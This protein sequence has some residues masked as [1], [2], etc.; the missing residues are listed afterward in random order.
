M[1]KDKNSKNNVTEKLRKI[2]DNKSS[3]KDFQSD[4]EKYLVSLDKRLKKTSD[5]DVVYKQMV[6]KNSEQKDE[7]LMKPK[8][9]IHMREKKILEIFKVKESEPKIEVLT[10]IKEKEQKAT[11][12]D[13]FEIEKVEVVG[14]R[15]IEVK[16]KVITKETLPES[17]ITITEKELPEWATVE[18][19]EIAKTKIETVERIEGEEKSESTTLFCTYCNA[20]LDKMI[21]FCPVCGHK[22]TTESEEE[23]PKPVEHLQSK[24]TPTFIPV[25]KVEEDGSLTWEPV[26]IEKPKEEKIEF[27]P[28]EPSFVRER[29]VEAFK[30]MESINGDTAVLLYDNG[31]TSVDSLKDV[32][33]KNLTKIKGI[34]RRTAKKIKKEIE[35][36][37]EKIDQIIPIDISETAK[38]DL[39]EEQVKNEEI[40]ENKED[41]L[42]PVELSRKS[43]EWAPVGEV[44]EV[45]EK[46]ETISKEEITIVE[47]LKV[48]EPGTPRENKIEAF[49]GIE[50]INED[51][52]VLLYDN[53]FTSIDSLK[54][55]TVKDIRKIKGIKRRTAKKI[56]KEL[57]KITEPEPIKVE[58]KKPSK[59]KTSVKKKAKQKKAD[60]E[61]FAEYFI[62]EDKKE[63]AGKIEKEIKEYEPLKAKDED[64]FVE[65]V[66]EISLQKKE[67][68]NVFRGMRSIDGKTARLLKENG[69]TSIDALNKANIKD[70]V[71]I[72]G[73]KRKVAKNIK[74]EVSESIEKKNKV[75]VEKKTYARG[76][77]P[78]IKGEDEWDSYDE[79]KIS[80]SQMIETKGYTQGDF[81]LYEK[82]IET[83]DKKMKTVRFF[84]KAEPEDGKPIE[85]PEG[86]EVKENPKTGI[87]YLKKKK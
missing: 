52:A 31:F 47:E 81:T 13:V 49:K 78:F 63:E 23:K 46:K 6:S 3:D 26:E 2:L 54:N 57:E 39:T 69:I 11:A 79:G 21:N 45:P 53:G 76:E 41:A 38:I 66:E 71:K 68:E 37:L 18:K 20:P 28:R 33:I 27:V 51:T 35:K 7:D 24:P 61:G 85:L 34:K 14:P 86:Y 87:P 48:G 19:K 84:S 1:Q 40:A 62:D 56:K 83:K 10:I 16:P 59:R 5:K 12:E 8:I 15:F 29:K 65:E 58:E 64:F 82:T 9:S 80:E 72:K 32:S 22:L 30:G 74:K 55:A 17:K 75:K 36:K 25:K 43:S 44:E 42:A 50:S 67:G 70:L 4:N 60:K 73:I 77:N